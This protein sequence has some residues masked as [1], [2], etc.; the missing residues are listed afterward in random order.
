MEVHSAGKEYFASCS[1]WRKPGNV[2]AIKNI[3]AYYE[4]GIVFEKSDAKALEWYLKAKQ[5][6]NKFVDDDILRVKEKLKK[7]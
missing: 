4:S 2:D 3:A 7:K 5:A 6:G 1:E